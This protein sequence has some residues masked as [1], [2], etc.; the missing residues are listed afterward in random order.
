MSESVKPPRRYRSPLRDRQAER[1]RT[2]ILD[3]AARHLERD[4]YGGSTLRQ[5]AESAGVAVE[6]V[7]ATFG[8]KAVL[9]A[10]V[11]ERN[12]QAAIRRAV[13]GG[14][15]RALIAGRDLEAQLATFGQA[16]PAIMGPN[17][18]IMEALRVGGATDAEL[19]AAYRTGSE[20]RRGWMRGFVEAWSAMGRLR[21]DIDVN[22]ATDVLWAITA[23]DVYRLLVVE[24][25]WSNERYAAWLTDA[26]RALVLR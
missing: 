2:S 11:G 16:A 1:T 4:G 26:A 6:T 20:G 17:W 23:A 10:A 14:D 19:A 13:P 7:Y 8:S 21:P 3:A 18:A 5:I 15:L 9:F 12:L 24:A 25:G 22:A